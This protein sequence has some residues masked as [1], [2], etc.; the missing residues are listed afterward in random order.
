LAA[1]PGFTATQCHPEKKKAV[2]PYSLFKGY[3]DLPT[4]LSSPL[5]S[6]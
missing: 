5:L 6:S 3:L 4:H 2:L 1:T